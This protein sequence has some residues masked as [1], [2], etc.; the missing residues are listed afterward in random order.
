VQRG[1]GGRRFLESCP[2]GGQAAATQTAARA[3]CPVLPCAPIV[4]GPVGRH[5]R[6][7]FVG[8]GQS[9]PLFGRP[10]CQAPRETVSE[11]GPQRR[12]PN[13][14]AG[15]R[16]RKRAGTTNPSASRSRG[17]VAPEEVPDQVRSRHPAKVTLPQDARA[18]QVA[19]GVAQGGDARGASR[20]PAGRLGEGAGRVRAGEASAE[21]PRAGA[22]RGRQ[23]TNG[24]GVRGRVRVRGDRA[25]NKAPPGSARAAGGLGG[26]RGVRGGSPA[27]RTC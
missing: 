10:P 25:A 5:Q 26:M 8:R 12:R 9:I 22:R 14:R 24:G 21:G 27:S 17:G 7:E 1:H 20:G 18:G 2:A 11:S 23:G 16:S 19:Q 3:P 6:G 15:Q 4:P 13:M